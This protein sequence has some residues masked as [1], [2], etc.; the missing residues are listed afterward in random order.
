MEDNSVKI[1]KAAGKGKKN[2]GLAFIL[3]SLI[4]L[5]KSGALLNLVLMFRWNPRRALWEELKRLSLNKVPWIVGGDFNTMLHTHEYRGATISSLGSIED[6]NDMVLDSG[7]TDAGFEGEPFTWSNKRV[8]R[9]L[10][11]VLYSQEWA[12]LF[13]ST[14][15]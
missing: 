11:R 7:L 3:V 10:D 5:T 12:E 13:N 14:R 8:W 9:R 4:F 15:V 6:F 1:G 2:K